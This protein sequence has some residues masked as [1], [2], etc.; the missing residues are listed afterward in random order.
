MI[1]YI[2][3][4]QGLSEGDLEALL[5][6]LSRERKEKLFRYRFFSDRLQSALAFVL[7]RFGLKEEYGLI[8]MPHLTYEEH[9]KPC[10]GGYPDICFNLSH[11]KHSVACGIARTP[12]GV[13]IQH[14]VPYKDDL[15]AYFMTEQERVN[16]KAGDAGSEFTRMW[17]RKESYGKYLGSGI[18]YEMSKLSL[19]E[20][21]EIAGVL[22]RSHRLPFGYLSVSCAEAVPIR[23]ISYGVLLDGLQGLLQEEDT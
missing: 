12:L 10:L 7:L 22:T 8:H 23:K 18:C 19:W 4:I 3:D 17:T 16:A 21:R 2:D 14:F 15:A 1:Y 20:D 9:G 6:Y 11:C 5:P 13:D